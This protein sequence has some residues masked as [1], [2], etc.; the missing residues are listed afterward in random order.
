MARGF[1]KKE[2]GQDLIEY[3]TPRA[4]WPAYLLTGRKVDMKRMAE[5]LKGE[6]GQDLVEYTLLL[7]FVMMT[8]VA[9]YMNA[10]GSVSGIWTTTNTK[11]DSGLVAAGS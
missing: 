7:A 3:T 2:Q 6:Q 1:L 5:F 4:V 10:G 8:T 11:L 9:L